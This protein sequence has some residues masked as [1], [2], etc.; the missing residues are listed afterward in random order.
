[1]GFFVGLDWGF[2]L[3]VYW[4]SFLGVYWGDIRNIGVLSYRGTLGLK[5]RKKILWGIYRALMGSIIGIMEKNMETAIMGYI[6]IIGVYWDL[7]F[8]ICV[9]GCRV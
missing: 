7:K 5:P 3:R 9:S 2:F 8:R 1:M 6:L 4:G